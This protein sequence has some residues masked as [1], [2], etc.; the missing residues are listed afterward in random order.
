MLQVSGRTGK[1][2]PTF[3]WA[4]DRSADPHVITDWSKTPEIFA[5][6]CNHL[7]NEL[8]ICLHVR[9]KNEVPSWTLFHW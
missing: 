1:W 2:T 4:T 7:P 6:A 5:T 8:A 9:V 3:L